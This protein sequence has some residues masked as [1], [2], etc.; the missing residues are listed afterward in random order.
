MGSKRW[1]TAVVGTSIVQIFRPLHFK[2]DPP[3]RHFNLSLKQKSCGK[4]SKSIAV[5]ILMYENGVL[6][7]GL[8]SFCPCSAD[9]GLPPWQPVYIDNGFGGA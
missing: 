6:G 7:R 2:S 1:Y 4:I 3:Q 8:S 9:Y 5:D